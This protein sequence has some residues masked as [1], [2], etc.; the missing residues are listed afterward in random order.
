MRTLQ[1]LVQEAIKNRK[2]STALDGPD[3]NKPVVW[4]KGVSIPLRETAW[5]ALILLWDGSAVEFA[6]LGESCYGDDCTPAGTITSMVK[7]LCKSL[8]KVGVQC[9]CS[10]KNQRVQIDRYCG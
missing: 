3:P 10:F 2:R 7:R 8:E 5:R 4:V 1:E 6:Q 9:S